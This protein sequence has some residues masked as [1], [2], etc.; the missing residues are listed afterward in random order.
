GG[1][2]GGAGAGPARRAGLRS[3]AAAR[4]QTRRTADRPGG[5]GR[6]R[7]ALA[8]PAFLRGR[9][10]AAARP[11]LSGKDTAMH[12]STV[13]T[14]AGPFS[15]V[16]DTDGAVLAFGWTAE[17]DDLV[18]L[19]SPELRAGTPHWTDDLGTTGEAVRAYHDGDLAAVRDVA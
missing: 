6:V 11:E 16:V 18:P 1:C 8:A 17:L 13:D 9:A 12:W 2:R 10:A 14:P 15:A 4:R 19:I 7:A 5:A 3:H